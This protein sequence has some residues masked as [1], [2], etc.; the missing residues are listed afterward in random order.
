MKV[1]TIFLLVLLA[2]PVEACFILIG[3]RNGC[4][5]VGNNEDWDQ[6]DAK[7][8]I[9][10]PRPGKGEKYST[11]FFGFKGEFTTAQGGVNEKGLFFDATAVPVLTLTEAAKAGKEKAIHPIFKNIL[12]QCATVEEA[13]R[14]LEGVYIPFIKKVQVVLVDAT[15]AYLVVNVNGIA[16]RGM[17]SDTY[18]IITN[19]HV[20]DRR[21]FCYRYD[22]A[23]ARLEKH[24]DNTVEEFKG[25][26][27]LNHQNFPGATVY[28][29]VFNLTEGRAHVFYNHQ[30][31]NP[32]T[33]DLQQEIA[34]KS[35]QFTYLEEK[36]R[37]RMIAALIREHKKKGAEG[38]LRFFRAEK[39]NANSPYE[40][41]AG[42]L[43][44]LTTR[45]INQQHFADAVPVAR[46]NVKWYP[47]SDLAHEQLGKALLYTGQRETAIEEYTKALSINPNNRWARRVLQQYG[48]PPRG[49][50][51]FT[52][53][54]HPN[55][56]LVTLCGEFN[57]WQD[58]QN[59]AFRNEA[60]QW[61][62]GLDLPAGQ[63]KYRFMVD[64]IFI[65]DPKRP[66]TVELQKDFWVSVITVGDP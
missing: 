58:L 55:A 11:L 60:G 12:K 31:D 6:S 4:V 33:I 49:R 13:A 57:E 40:V 22:S 61:E 28:S 52:L 26:L 44:D 54:G 47:S 39:G 66:P 24:F 63:Y 43:A 41:D 45:L 29:T 34:G 2:V 65:D 1:L 62:C 9:E 48:S 5:L 42:Q 10:H 46:E 32:I 7:Y 64:G 56:F 18:R 3:K 59:I 53:D 51:K 27:D 30:F 23:E 21:H 8:W 25:L 37:K 36:F 15:G 38:A 19:F 50:I 16:E 17:V 20:S 35:K 14:I